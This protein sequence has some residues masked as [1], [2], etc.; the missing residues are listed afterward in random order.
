MRIGFASAVSLKRLAHLVD[1]GD[2]LP[3]TYSFNPASDWVKELLARGHQITLYTTGFGM[4]G[5]QTFRGDQLTIRVASQR[6][7][8]T[9]RDFFA[10]ERRQMTEMMQ[11]DQCPLIHAH[12]TY[13]FALAA[14]ASGLPTLITIHDLPWNVL[15]YFRDP[16]RVVR[17]LM[18]YQ[19]ALRGKHFTAVSTD[20]VN[21][22]R[23]YMKPGAAI[24]MV[25]N[26]LP[27]S[28]FAAG[29]D[30]AIRPGS[31]LRFATI[32]QGWSAR[33]NASAALEA[34]QLVR[35]RLPETTLTMIGSD[36]GPGEAAEQWAKAKGL[37]AGVR[38]IGLMAYEEL[39]NHVKTD[40]DALVHPSLDESFSMAALEGMSLRK[41]VIAGK[42]TP[43]IR[44][45]LAYGQAGMLVDM[46]DPAKIAEAMCQLALDPEYR[47]TL[48]DRAY[49]RACTHY[50]TSDVIDQY[51]SL[52]RSILAC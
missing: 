12:W 24:T 22:F 3:S 11:E 4:T 33:K 50:K 41:P 26:G 25:P 51:E 19:V 36:Y 45:V 35:A 8:G 18:A 42:D 44:E 13:E 9:G 27:E 20:A 21:H 17:L 34:F 38:F 6:S 16:Y 37:N 43:G 15:R 29:R 28:F 46:K 23:R 40:V 10:P 52:Y 32:L 2:R 1:G 7:R 30:I 48:A 49:E 14:L 31:D 39:L 5:P 47:R